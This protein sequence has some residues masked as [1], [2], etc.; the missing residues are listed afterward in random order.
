MTFPRKLATASRTKVKY[1]P[2]VGDFVRVKTSVESYYSRYAGNPRIVLDRTIVGIIGAVNVPCVRGKM[3][4][5]PTFNCVDFHCDLTG[6]TERAAVVS[7][8]LVLVP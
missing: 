3:Q 2:S 8:N 4:G 5:H 6:R 7:S 1:V